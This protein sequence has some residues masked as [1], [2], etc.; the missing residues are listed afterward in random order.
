[1]ELVKFYIS[2]IHPVLEYAA[3]VWHTSITKKQKQEIEDLQ[4]RVLR[5]IFPER[6]E[7]CG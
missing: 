6:R 2:T 4:K 3:L 5:I 7:I 1:M